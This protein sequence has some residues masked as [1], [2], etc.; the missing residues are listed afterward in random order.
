MTES[1]LLLTDESDLV[2]AIRIVCYSNLRL[3]IQNPVQRIMPI[4][5]VLVSKDQP[6]QQVL[7]GDTSD[8]D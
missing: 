6:S 5:T 1:A 8:S 7:N 3:L 4:A 2:D